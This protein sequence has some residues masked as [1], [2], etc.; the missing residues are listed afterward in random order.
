MMQQ[1]VPNARFVNVPR[2]SIGYLEMLIRRMGVSFRR[3]IAVKRN[4]ISHKI[5]LELLNIFARPFP[6]REFFP[7]FKDIF[8]RDGMMIGMLELNSS[9]N[10]KAKPP[11]TDFARFRQG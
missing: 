9:H 1:P 6:A 7:C 8:E 5:T 2:F 11:P 3:K 10:F 4:D